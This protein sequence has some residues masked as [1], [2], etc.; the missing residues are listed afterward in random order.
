MFVI[1]S[2]GPLPSVFL[3]RSSRPSVTWQER[4]FKVN[5]RQKLLYPIFNPQ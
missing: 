1:V 5:Y 3:I 2:F 4:N